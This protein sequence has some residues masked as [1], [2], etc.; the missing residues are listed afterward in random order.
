MSTERPTTAER[1]AELRAQ[2]DAHLAEL[3]ERPLPGWLASRRNRRALALL[4]AVTLACGLVAA[5]SGDGPLLLVALPA[6][7]LSAVVAILLLRRATR[8]LDS[9][10]DRLLDE[11]EVGVRDDAHRRAHHLVLGL[12]T[13]GWLL[14]LADRVVERD[15]GAELVT[16]DGWIFLFITLLLVVSAL[17]AAVLAWRY[18]EVGDED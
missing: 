3:R 15:G 11:R 4:P 10:P 17:P 9:A 2:T 16:G 7:S 13:G 8:L 1:R 12:L 18:E 6:V 5:T 14:A